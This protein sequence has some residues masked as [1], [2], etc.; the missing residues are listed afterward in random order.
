MAREFSGSAVVTGG[1]TG[2]GNAICRRLATD[3]HYVVY[4][5]RTSAPAQDFADLEESISFIGGDVSNS[6]DVQS[7]LEAAVR[8]APL[9]GWVNNAAMIEDV[10]LHEASDEHIARVLS[11]NLVGT[12]YGTRTAVR[13]FLRTETAGSIVNVSSIHGRG[14]FP[15]NPIY[16]TSKGGVDAITRYAAVEYGHLGIR[17]NAVAPGAIRTRLLN[18]VIEAA[19]DSRAAEADFAAL[20]VLRRLG[21]VEEVADVVAYLL[22][23]QAS[24][25]NGAII[26]VDSGSAAR[27]YPFPQHSSVPQHP[28]AGR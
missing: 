23:E 10:A 14:A 12:L 3:G 9:R 1:S 15:G 21:E 7:A 13:E 4:I 18:E 22:G 20:N 2:I 5:S 24:F 6:A 19:P 11:V 17:V 27:V 25:V 28:F 26:P 8:V 16:D